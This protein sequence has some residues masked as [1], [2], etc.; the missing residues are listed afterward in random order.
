[1]NNPLYAW[2]GRMHFEVN[3]SFCLANC[4]SHLSPLTFNQLN[5]SLVIFWLPVLLACTICC[6]WQSESTKKPTNSLSSAFN[7]HLHLLI[8]LVCLTLLFSICLFRSPQPSC[9]LS[10]LLLLHPSFT[11]FLRLSAW[12]VPVTTDV[13]FKNCKIKNWLL[14]FYTRVLGDLL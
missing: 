11:C 5:Q 12:T 6:C 4:W 8:E 7:L 14:T 13:L 3:R 2:A 1:M 9:S 10:H